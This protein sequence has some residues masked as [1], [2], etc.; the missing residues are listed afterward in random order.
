MIFNDNNHPAEKE[1]EGYHEQHAYRNQDIM[2]DRRR[3]QL[4]K[5]FDL[6][7]LDHN[8]ILEKS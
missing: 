1:L 8:G 6:I 7:D 4:M 2:S 5:E 3:D